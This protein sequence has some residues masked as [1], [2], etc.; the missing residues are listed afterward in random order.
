MV[1][2]NGEKV[3][4]KKAPNFLNNIQRQNLWINE[5]TGA[6]FAIMKAP[7]GVYIEESPHNHPHANQF[8]FNLSGEGEFPNGTKIS[9]SEDDYVFN[10]TPKNEKHGAI[11]EG[12]RILKDRIYLHYW[13]G[14]DDWDDQEG[15]K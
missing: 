14:P 11:P 8:T 7:K 4:W 13:D 5:K 10:Y 12:S 3:E 6:T 2:V 9:F 1:K 15:E